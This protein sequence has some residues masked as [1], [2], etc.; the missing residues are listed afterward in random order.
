MNG[1]LWQWGAAG[2]LLLPAVAI[3]WKQWATSRREYV[4]S[5]LERI[6]TR[7]A[8]IGELKAEIDAEQKA[9]KE[10]RHQ[11]TACIAR[12]ADVDNTD[13]EP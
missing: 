8:F 10:T 9:H 12:Q 2:A 3:L 7:D 4:D 6:K 5:L 1:E 13:P 11:L